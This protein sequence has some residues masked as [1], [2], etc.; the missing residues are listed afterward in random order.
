MGLKFNHG[1]NLD[2]RKERYT[3][4]TMMKQFRDPSNDILAG[5]FGS[6]PVTV[7]PMLSYNT[8]LAFL[9]KA[10]VSS[11]GF[12][13]AGSSAWGTT[14]SPGSAGSTDV[15]FWA[16]PSSYNVRISQVGD[17]A[18]KIYIADGARYSTNTISPDV[19]LTY[20]ASYG[21]VF[22]DQG[23]ASAFSHA[24]CRNRVPGN[25]GTGGLSDPRVYWARHT[26]KPIQ[27]ARGG[28]YRFNAGFFDG[29]V[30]TLDDLNGSNPKFWFPKG[31][32]FSNA[33]N[34]IWAD[35]R[36]HFG[37]PDTKYTVP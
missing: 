10:P 37:I 9:V 29:H 36:A 13:K 28:T 35:T 33:K 2:D 4:F 5:P 25:G 17:G 22:A 1:P 3:Q 14:V 31:T 6:V 7:G 24:W 26:S 19:D 11:P 15:G 20:N 32:V 8:A 27:G 30:E 18:Q 16:V 23:A 21:G 12:G 34:E